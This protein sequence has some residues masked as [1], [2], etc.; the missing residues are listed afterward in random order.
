[1]LIGAV[2]RVRAGRHQEGARVLDDQPARLHGDGARRRRVDRGGVPPLHARVLQGRPL[3][4]RGLG[5]P[6]GLAPLLRHEEGHGRP[7]QVHAADVLDV[8]HRLASRSRASSRSPGSGRRTR[9]S[10]TRA[11]T[12]TSVPR[13]R[14]RRR[15]HDRGVH[16][17]LRL[18]HVL[19]RVPRRSRRA[20][21]PIAG[22]V[23]EARARTSPTTQATVD[24]DAHGTAPHESNG[25]HHR[26]A[27]GAVVLRGLRR[28]PQLPALRA[29][30]RTGS[31]R[32]IPPGSTR[33]SCTRRVQPDPR[34][35]SRCSIALAAA[36]ARRGRST[37]GRLELARRTSRRAT[38]RARPASAS[39]STST[40]STACTRTSSSPASRARSR[41]AC[42]GSTSTSSTTSS[43]T[44]AGRD[45]RSAAS[46]TT[47]STRRASTVWSTAS[48]TVTGEAGGE[49][50]KIQTGRLQ[51]YALMLVAAVVVVRARPL[52]LHLGGGESAR[53]THLVRLVGADPRGLHPR[54][55]RGHH[56]A[57]AARRR[58][59]R[60]RR[61]R[62]LTTLATFGFTIAVLARFDYDT[63][64][65]L[66]FQV[67]KQWIDVINSRYHVG[68]DGIS[69]PLLALSAFITV[70]CVIYSW[71]HFPE[72]H[73]PKA[74]LAL[75]LDP[76]SRHERHVR[77][78]RTSS[79]SSSSS[80]SCCSR[81]SS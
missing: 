74:F 24:A 81:C 27:V 72:P 60:S 39:S 65:V 4:R 7:A 15:V 77:R 61:S 26:P 16:D 57:P 3:P 12:A 23:D 37:T 48:A 70:L 32:R 50:R 19:R 5:E 2:A 34:G 25:L 38:L 73:N 30:S 40:T 28:L 43:T 10:S 51:F 46:R 1:M 44:R 62:S 33:R 31:T 69:L 42:T 54:G 58:R 56:H 22:E 76:R 80:R 6:L 11:T 78:A 52:D 67:D 17:A 8:R 35:R 18:P 55:G 64:A 45:A 79:C 14:A 49:V 13:R 9:S 21:T 71:N 53:W 36:S 20:R 47:T 59:R 29:S 68:V 75:I 63:S 66:Q 41:A